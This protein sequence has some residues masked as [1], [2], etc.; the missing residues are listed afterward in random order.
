MILEGILSASFFVGLLASSVRLATPLL[1]AA[2]GETFAERAGVLNIGVEGIMIVGAL[3]GFLAGHFSGSPWLGAL[4]G[5]LAGILFSC[6]HAYLCTILGANQVVS[7]L[8]INLLALGLAVFAFRAAFGIPASDPR[9]PTFESIPIPL[10][11]KIPILGD[12][13]FNQHAWVYLSWLLVPVC[14]LVLFKTP[15]GLKVTAV[16]ETPIAA[17]AAGVNVRTTR[18]VAVLIGGALGGL[19]GMTL[20]LAQLGFFKE[21][22][23]AGRGFIAIAIVMFG[24]WNPFGVLIAALLFGTADSLQLRLQTIGVEHYLPPQLLVSLPY[25]LTLLALLGRSGRKLIPSAL[26][27]PYKGSEDR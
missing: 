8:A 13:F 11:S 24:R 19:G 27:V 14:Y 7:G 3:A 17:E 4:A 16:G 1:L 25:L 10:L 5:C 6:I 21:V 12:I 20:A 23:V 15:W 2:L 18:F 9:S 26:A 22:M